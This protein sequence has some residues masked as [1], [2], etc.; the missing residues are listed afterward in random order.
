MARFSGRRSG[1]DD[2]KQLR[3][4]WNS[5]GSDAPA[6][7]AT[8]ATANQPD[9]Q[10]GVLVQRLTW[11]FKTSFPQPTEQA[12]EEGVVDADDTTPD[13]IR[14]IHEEHSRQMLAALH[15]LDIV[16]D[17]RRRGVDPRNNKA[18]MLAEAKQRLQKFFETEPARL[19]R[20][21]QTLLDTYADTFGIEAGEQFNKAIRARHAGI[22]VVAG[23][24]P[25]SAQEPAKRRPP[26]KRRIAAVLP[27]PRP[28]P[29]AV[30]AARFGREEDGRPVRPGPQEVR[31]ITTRHAEQLV[32]LLDSIQQAASGCAPGE[33]TRLMGLFDTGIAAYAEDFGE[34]PARQLEAYVRRQASLDERDTGRTTRFR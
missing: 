16:M 34:R 14:S 17:A 30:A 2:A 33:R 1:G 3:I 6:T 12:V 19:E 27:V 22:G 7:P 31:A 23:D 18:P 26:E 4:D 32:D 29:A 21:Y 24:P 5:S 15:D 11:D 8:S 25:K 20:W 13:G 28:L 10:A 9:K